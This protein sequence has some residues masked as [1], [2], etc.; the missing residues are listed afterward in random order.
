MHLDVLMTLGV[1]IRKGKKGK[2]QKAVCKE[3]HTCTPSQ[4]HTLAHTLPA[5][6][7]H[8]GARDITIEGKTGKLKVVR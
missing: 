7:Y 1:V 5:G 3:T 8:T 2:A 6:V 4:T